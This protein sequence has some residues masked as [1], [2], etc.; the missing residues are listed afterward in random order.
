MLV[1]FLS[2][3]KFDQIIASVWV[4]NFHKLC[5]FLE[6]MNETVKFRSRGFSGQ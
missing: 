4:S 2:Y 3:R 5:T 6:K 1:L